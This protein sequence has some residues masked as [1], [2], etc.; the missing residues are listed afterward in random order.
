MDK[1]SSIDDLFFLLPHLRK[2]LVI[3]VAVEKDY[4]KNVKDVSR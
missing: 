4:N 1:S 3:N 2:Y